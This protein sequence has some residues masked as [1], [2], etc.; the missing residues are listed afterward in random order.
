VTATDR[1]ERGPAAVPPYRL[2]AITDDLRDGRDG[3]VARASAAV[4]GGATMVQ[5]RL[6]HIDAQVVVEIGR[7]LVERLP[8]PV[9]LNDRADIA[10]ACGAAGVHVGSDDVPAAA[11]RRFVPPGFLIG[12]SVGSDAEVANAVGGDYVG[13]GPI[14][15]SASKLD[16][17]NAIGL[18][19]LAHLGS[20]AALPAVAIGGI[21]VA[22]AADVVAAGA[23]GV[24][25][26]AAIFGAS[27]PEAAAHA[28]RTAIDRVVP[29][30]TA[31]PVVR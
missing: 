15:G 4:R 7:A 17:G 9:I 6:K 27:D 1:P 30:S 5:L 18:L 16:A 25:V 26:I 20:A 28:L 19:G 14:Y 3:L 23:S 21:T 13:I 2:I 24:A 10:L 22:T 12:V 31:R 8:V 29:P 11:L